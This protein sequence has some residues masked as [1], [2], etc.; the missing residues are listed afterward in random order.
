MM[1]FIMS[2]ARMFGGTP[3]DAAKIPL[4]LASAPELAQVTGQ[5]FNVMKPA[6]PSKKAQ[7]PELARRLW[8]VSEQ[9]TGA[10]M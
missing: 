6:S 8:E 5:Y 9:L 3:A 7:D 10:K 2:I 1:G 4:R